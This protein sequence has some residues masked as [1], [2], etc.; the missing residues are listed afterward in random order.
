MAISIRALS[1]TDLKT[2]DAIIQ[3]AFQR[4]ESSLKEL[5]LIRKLQPKGAFIAYHRETPV[6]VVASLI[7]PHFA[8]AGPLGVHKEFQR[9]GIG[10]ALMRHLLAWLD[11]QEVF[12]VLLDA[13]PLGQPLYE[14]LD[15]ISLDQVYVLQQ[16]NKLSPFQ[17]PPEVEPLTPQ[18]LDLVIATDKQ[19]FGTN[20]RK[21]L[22][23]LI[24]A[25]PKRGFI[26]RDGQG[27]VNGYLIA[28]ERNIGP[29]ISQTSADA[30]LLLKAALSLQFNGPVSAIVPEEN[31][32]AIPML[33]NFGFEI[34]RV[35]QHMVRGAKPP[36]RQREKLFGQT[37]LSLG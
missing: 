6:G 5:R 35:L 19:V 33:Q 7:Y 34:A 18:N 30:E 4:S 31:V 25:Y 9:Q 10:L 29:W 32:E 28:Q 15:F 22:Q 27:R 26:F 2:A 3:S 17:L 36:A 16:K 24:E 11:K 1:E 21:L 37:S 13:S 12:H 8:Y 20:R 14:K 23:A